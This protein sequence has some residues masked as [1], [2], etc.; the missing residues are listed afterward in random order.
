VAN[1]I[2]F[3]HEARVIFAGPYSEMEKSSEP[4]LQEF[5]ELDE[6]KLEV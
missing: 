3:L 5:V 6:L 1:R 2:I 4:I